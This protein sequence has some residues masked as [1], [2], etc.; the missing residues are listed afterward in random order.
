[1]NLDVKIESMAVTIDTV[2]PKVGTI[3]TYLIFSA[4]ISVV[5][6]DTKK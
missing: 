2:N 5:V 1:M 3:C 4:I 6:C